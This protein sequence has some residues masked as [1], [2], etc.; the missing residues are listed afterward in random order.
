MPVIRTSMRLDRKLLDEVVKILGA[1]SRSEA[2]DMA[3][4]QCVAAKI[5]LKPSKPK[6]ESP[7]PPA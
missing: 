2:I 4:R 3:L 6:I 7:I 5:P 1:K